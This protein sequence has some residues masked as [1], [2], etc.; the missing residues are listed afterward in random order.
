MDEY[1]E[2]KKVFKDT[3]GML[4]QAGDQMSV[5]EE[6]AS[7]FKQKIKKA[8]QVIQTLSSKQKD[9][10]RQVQALMD[11]LDQI[12]D[13]LEQTNEGQKQLIKEMPKIEDGAD[14]LTDGQKAIK[15]GFNQLSSKL[16]LLTD[17]LDESI[18]GLEQVK[19]GFTEAGGYLKQLQQAP[20]EEITGW[21]IPEDV[22]KR[23]E[24][25]QI[26]KTYMSPDRKLTTL[27]VIL[28]V[29]PYSNEAMK[30]VA[31]I[32]DTLDQYLPVSGLKNVNYGV[33]GIS[34]L[35]VDLKETSDGDFIRTVIFMLIGIFI[36][37]IILLRSIVMPIYLTLS[38][39]LTYFTSIGL[40]EWIFKTFFGYDGV[41]WAVPFFSFVILVTLGIDYSI[42][43]MDRFNEWKGEHVQASMISA[44]RNMG[45][46][47]ISAVAILAGTFAAMLPSGVLSLVEIATVVLIGL[48]LYAFVVLP[49][50]IPVMVR[51]FGKWN[52]WPFRM[53]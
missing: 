15:K 2:I 20:D 12:Y 6:E 18:E 23:H 52:W 8:D 51:I 25:K 40:T 21:F 53:K 30:G 26:F 11:G 41:S 42:F 1:K 7:H 36:I 31:K 5:Y 50:F 34:S 14:Q 22:L 43:L 38:L 13:G 47:I 33:S 10:K 28:N 37:L 4:D 49:L 29:N 39:I 44:M 24:F 48:L 19:S 35:N 9:V 45:S 17:G 32:E 46:V 16:T 27:E 3:K